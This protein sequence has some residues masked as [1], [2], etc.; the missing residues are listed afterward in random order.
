[1]ED[2]TLNLSSSANVNLTGV[3]F[4]GGTPTTAKVR[5]CVINVTSTS[6][7][8]SPTICG[9]FSDGTTAS[10]STITS[11]NAVQ[12]TTTNVTSTTTGASIVRGWY[13]TGSLQFS[14]RDSVVFASGPGTNVIGVETTNSASLIIVKTS[15]VSGTTF[16]IK[17]PSGL[18]TPVLYLAYTDLVNAN[19]NGNGFG[20]NLEQNDKY[21]VLGSKVSF[22]GQGSLSATTQ[23]TYYC[24]PGTTLS[25]FASVITGIPF[26]HKIIL[27]GA[28]LSTSILLTSTQV[29][30]L[31]LYKSSS[32]ATTGTLLK[33]LAIN[34]TTNVNHFTDYC[35]TFLP[36]T[37]YLHVE[38]VV[39]GADLAT[40]NNVVVGISF[41]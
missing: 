3:Y 22:S 25:N 36:T 23:G 40:G 38:V 9:I 20:V 7:S 14:V 12:R 41:Y 29:V 2:L 6:T 18:A 16:D 27:N 34:S 21:F 15:T 31:N 33:S 8:S 24:L 39:S 13:F 5:A 26:P 19:A 10:Y 1:M 17:Q 4:P 30:T 11:L 35:V 37:E 28:I 32:P